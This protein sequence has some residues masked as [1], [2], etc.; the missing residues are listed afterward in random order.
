MSRPPSCNSNSVDESGRRANI[1]GM[2]TSL[3]TNERALLETLVPLGDDEAMVERV[4]S[5][6]M[7]HQGH[8][9]ARFTRPMHARLLRKTC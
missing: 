1:G 9:G 8:S 7:P 5:G 4:R 6:Y 2:A 3:I